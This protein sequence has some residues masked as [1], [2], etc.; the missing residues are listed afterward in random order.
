MRLNKDK[1]HSRKKAASRRSRPDWLQSADGGRVIQGSGPLRE[2]S[3]GAVSPAEGEG[4][5]SPEQVLGVSG[6]MEAP[7]LPWDTACV[8]W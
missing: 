2:E 3:T 4:R 6:S 7:L 5:P 1:D 8:P